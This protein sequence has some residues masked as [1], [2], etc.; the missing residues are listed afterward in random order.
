MNES[1]SN[2]KSALTAAIL[3]CT[4]LCVA[5]CSNSSDETLAGAASSSET[6]TVTPSAT[7]TYTTQPA[8]PTIANS[9]SAAV[10]DPGYNVEWR[11]RQVSYGDN[12]GAVFYMNLKN[13][14]DVP[15]PPEALPVPELLVLGNNDTTPAPVSLIADPTTS[16]TTATTATNQLSSPTPVRLPSGLDLPLG[17]G[18]TATVAYTFNTTVASLANAQLTIGNVSWNGKLNF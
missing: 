3:C 17:A 6:V 4:A 13:L 15:L 16:T 10:V 14:N 8:A 18:A 12:G 5:S 7:P 9:P 11:I 2:R 1:L